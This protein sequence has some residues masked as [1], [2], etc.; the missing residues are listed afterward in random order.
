MSTAELQHRI[1]LIPENYKLYSSNDR[2]D[3]HK[4]RRPTKAF[5]N[6]VIMCL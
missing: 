2:I 6:H 3:I 4:V 5:K 1:Y